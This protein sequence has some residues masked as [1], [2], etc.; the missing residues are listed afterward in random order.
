M[1]PLLTE[2]EA[3]AVLCLSVKT[4]RTWRCRKSGPRY[5]KLGGAVRYAISDLGEYV[6]QCAR[7]AGNG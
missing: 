4:L 1:E 5:I 2:N 3:A 6:Q 7:D